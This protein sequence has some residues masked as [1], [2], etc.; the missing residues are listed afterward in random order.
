MFVLIVVF[1][2]ILTLLIG[3][4]DFLGRKM[5]IK[6]LDKKAV[7]ITGC[8]SGFGRDLV[9][10]CLLNG[11]TVFAGCRREIVTSKN[12]ASLQSVKELE[13]SYGSISQGRLYAFQ[14]DVADDESVRKSRKL[15][16]SVLR[17]K[18]LVLHALVNNAAMRGNIFYDDFLI[19]D[20]Y[21]EIWNVNMLGVVRVTQTFRDLIKQS[22]GRIIMCNTGFLLFAIPGHSPYTASK[23]AL[24]GYTN[25]IR[26][27]LQPYGVEVI[28]LV[29]GAFETGIQNMEDVS[30]MINTVWH[31]ASQEQRDEIGND[32]CRE[33][34][35]F[36]KKMR[37]MILVKDTTCV[38]DAY[39]EAI[40]AKRPKLL[41]RIGR[42]VL[43]KYHPYS[44]LPISLQLQIMNFLMYITGA[45]LPA[46][47]KQN[48]R[49]QN[50]ECKTD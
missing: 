39:Y 5:T 21:K 32:Y 47:Q 35:A 36:F 28:E 43:F 40:V 41:Y 19:L 50:A 44:F 17:E 46:V 14:M 33:A 7:L 23:Y 18:G 24:H 9:K 34:Q 10:R 16:D 37:P 6:E 12:C 20:D 22:R 15:V 2:I 13:E 26:H 49:L 29:P 4:Y 31:R 45:P 1:L 8:G 30:N 42:D 48:K 25:V 11:L 38:I 3:I 27:E